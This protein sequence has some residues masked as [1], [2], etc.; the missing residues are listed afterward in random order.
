VVAPIIGF[1]GLTVAALVK[2]VV[3]E[4]TANMARKKLAKS[5]LVDRLDSKLEKKFGKDF[6]KDKLTPDNLKDVRET[7]HEE[8]GAFSSKI[9]LDQL[10]T[11]SIQQLSDEHHQILTKIERVESLLEKIVIPTSYGI[12]KETGGEIP[13][14]LI[15]GLLE[16]SIRG[17]K[18]SSRVIDELI[19]EHRLSQDTKDFV[20]NFSFVNQIVTDGEEEM[21]RIVNK[22]AFSPQEINSLGT[23]MDV[24]ALMVGSN[25]QLNDIIRDFVFRLIEQGLDKPMIEN[26]VVSFTFILYR[27]GK[28]DRLSE[29]DRLLLSSFLKKIII[30]IENPT[31]V[32]EAYFLL[33]E[34]GF[35]AEVEPNYIL[36]IMERHYKQSTSSTKEM[37]N[38][39]KVSGRLARFLKRLSLKSYDVRSSM[40]TIRVLIKRLDKRKFKRSTQLLSYQL[41]RLTTEIN[42]LIAHWEKK[43][44]SEEEDLSDLVELLQLL[45]D[46][47]NR[48][49]ILTLNLESRKRIIECMDS[50]YYLYDLLAIRNSW[51]LL[52][53]FQLNIK[54]LYSPTL[55]K[56]QR[57]TTNQAAFNR[58]LAE[59]SRKKL[60]RTEKELPSPPSK[61]LK[62]KITD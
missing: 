62:K 23:L 22:F 3:A 41:E 44:P 38:Q 57:I 48:P 25:E 7:I 50:A 21:T 43:D 40:K 28:L 34:L 35:T 30:D 37:T 53:N 46:I 36:E 11:N 59:Y 54:S 61:T 33:V 6:L 12:T 19:Q 16:G 49:S 42:L 10:I 32:L 8:L 27:L 1:A 15:E 13:Q 29:S 14:E 20:N 45:L 9:D 5:F 51:N 31:R 52:N 2:A 4:Y 26:S 60:E 55:G 47:L 17:K 58:S 56:Y 39:L 18:H 24:S